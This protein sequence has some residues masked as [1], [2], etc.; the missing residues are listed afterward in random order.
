MQ[1]LYIIQMCRHFASRFDS[2][3]DENRMIAFATLLTVYV[4]NVGDTKA[5]KCKF[6]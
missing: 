6:W 2:D 1:V 5:Q 4:Q 3:N